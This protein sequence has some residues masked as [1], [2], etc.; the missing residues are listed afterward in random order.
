MQTAN[1][2]F[3][4]NFNAFKKLIIYENCVIFTDLFKELHAF[5]PVQIIHE[6][7]EFMPGFEKFNKDSI[8]I[9]DKRHI[10]NDESSH[11]H[12]NF[13]AMLPSKC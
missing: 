11:F 7:V 3:S 9:C 10:P 8:F 6:L 5:M 4:Q 12:S 2:V 1:Y 13:S